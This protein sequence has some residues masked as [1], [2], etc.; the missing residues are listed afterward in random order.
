MSRRSSDLGPVLRP[1]LA[2]HGH[3]RP[4]PRSAGHS[5]NASTQSEIRF[6]SGTSISSAPGP[7]MPGPLPDLPVGDHHAAPAGS[8]SG[9]SPMPPVQSSTVSVASIALLRRHRAA[10]PAPAR[11]APP[12]ARPSRRRGRCRRAPAGGRAAPAPRRASAGARPAPT[13]SRG[14]ARPGARTTRAAARRTAGARCS[15]RNARAPRRS[16]RPSGSATNR[17]SPSILVSVLPV[18]GSPE[19]SIIQTN[20][21]IRLPRPFTRS[22]AAMNSAT[23]GSSVS[24]TSRPMLSW[25]RC[26]APVDH[27]PR[28]VKPALTPGPNPATAGCTYDCACD[29]HAMYVRNSAVNPCLRGTLLTPPPPR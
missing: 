29:V 20:P 5:L 13:T 4:P 15:R 16:P 22:S 6:A 12:R 17:G 9:I 14:A 2:R 21:G 25:A 3:P 18:P 10:V 19:P 23:R 7:G 1:R 11:A 28:P 26:L 8:T 27:P 24:A